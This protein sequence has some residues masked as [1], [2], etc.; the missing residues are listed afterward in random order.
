MTHHVRHDEIEVSYRSKLC[1][2]RKF[3]GA[4]E[5]YQSQKPQDTEYA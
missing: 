3:D 1:Q 4:N 2:A 5:A